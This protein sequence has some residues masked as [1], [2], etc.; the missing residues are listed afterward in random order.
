MAQTK[1]AA[2]ASGDVIESRRQ[3][4]EPGRVITVQ[5]VTVS[6]QLRESVSKAIQQGQSADTGKK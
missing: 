3:V 6:Q 4:S 1:S 5:R 2:S